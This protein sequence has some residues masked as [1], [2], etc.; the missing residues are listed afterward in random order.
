MRYY[1]DIPLVIEFSEKG[2]VS[3]EYKY[4]MDIEKM[5]AFIA[6]INVF[7]YIIQNTTLYQKKKK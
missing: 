2:L 7:N 6:Y 5:D 4:Y 3:F 1:Y